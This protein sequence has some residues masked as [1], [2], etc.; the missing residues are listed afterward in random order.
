MKLAITLRYLATGD[1]YHSLMYGFR[2]SHSTISLIVRDV[3]EAI[4]EEFAAEVVTCPTAPNEWKIV[5]DQF[6]ERWQFFHA[7]GALDGKHI[8]IKCPRNGGSP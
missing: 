6:G 8:G 1:S 2:V 3:C 4:N 5:A 7:V